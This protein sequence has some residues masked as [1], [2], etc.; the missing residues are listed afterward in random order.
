MAS[1]SIARADRRRILLRALSIAASTVPYGAAFGV[2]AAD[3]G[4]T[5]WETVGFSS[6]VFTGSAQFAAVA[7]LGNG[8]AMAAAVGAGLL[9]NLRSLAFGIVLAPDLAGARWWRAIVSQ[10]VIDESTAVATAEREPALRRYGFLAG[11]VAVFALW[12]LSTVIGA[13]GLRSAGNVVERWGLDATIPAAFLALLWPRL[14][15]AAQ[16][17]VALGGVLIAVLLT[18]VA[19]AGIPVVAAI[20]AVAAGGR[21]R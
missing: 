2:I 11:G 13:A 5:L 3:A 14:R 15:D 8:G 20:A 6:F 9:L 12:N 17:R 19:P 4:L 7:I 16:R 18:P 21:R 10:L 1:S